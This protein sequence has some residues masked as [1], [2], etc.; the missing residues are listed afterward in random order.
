MTYVVLCIFAVAVV[1][2]LSRLGELR[3]VAT[4]VTSLTAAS[5]PPTDDTVSHLQFNVTAAASTTS[6]SAT[7]LP[8]PIADSYGQGNE[9]QSHSV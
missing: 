2:Q 3:Y 5:R 8:S 1:S 7:T 9:G 6:E 4:T